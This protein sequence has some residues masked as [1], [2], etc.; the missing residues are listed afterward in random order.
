MLGNFSNNK[1]TQAARHEDV[2]NLPL[3]RLLFTT[4][5]NYANFACGECYAL[6]SVNTAHSY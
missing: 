5:N 3:N 2:R 4:E 6:T 1:V